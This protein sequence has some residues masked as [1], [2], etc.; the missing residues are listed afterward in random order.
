MSDKTGVQIIPNLANQETKVNQAS[1][2]PALQQQVAQNLMEVAR[3]TPDDFGKMMKFKKG[4]FYSGEDEITSGREM[5]AHVKQIARGMVKFE[6]KKPVRRLIGKVADGFKMPDRNSLD[7]KHL[8]DTQ[9]DPWSA[10]AYLPLEDAETH[11]VMIFVASSFGAHKAVNRLCGIQAHNMHRG[12]PIIR[13]NV[14]GY[15]H[16]A[17]GWVDTPEFPVVGWTDA[18]APESPKPP[19]EDELSDEIPW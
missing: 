9:Q 11:E 14:T 8:I 6:N 15:T 18:D 17:F 4:K 2:L 19:A 1:N 5:I 16:K 12:S 13:L 3:E 7:D 10:Q